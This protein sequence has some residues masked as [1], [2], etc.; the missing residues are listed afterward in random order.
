MKNLLR[1]LAILVLLGTTLAL[2]APIAYAEPSGTEQAVHQLVIGFETQQQLEPELVTALSLLWETSS[3]EELAELAVNFVDTGGTIMFA[4]LPAWTA[5]DGRLAEI[6]LGNI[7]RYSM[8]DPESSYGNMRVNSL[9]RGS[10]EAAAAVIAHEAT[11]LHDQTTLGHDFL[12]TPTG[13]FKTEVNAFLTGMSVWSELR[14]R[15]D[16]LSSL[17][18]QKEREAVSALEFQFAF[19]SDLVDELEPGAAQAQITKRIEALY[20]DQCLSVRRRPAIGTTL[21]SKAAFDATTL[22][23]FDK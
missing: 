13:C 16:L 18:S 20:A 12:N 15:P 5:P 7:D 4:D 14:V 11:H 22:D 10:P 6:V 1:I 19:Y 2:P 17:P 9:L 21:W 8:F 23:R 3:G